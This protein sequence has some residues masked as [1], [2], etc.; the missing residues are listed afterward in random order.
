MRKNRDL[1]QRR[2]A[3]ILAALPGLPV[4]TREGARKVYRLWQREAFHP[5]LHFKKVGGDRWSIRVSIHYRAIGQFEG[6]RFVWS[7]IGTHGE[8]DRLA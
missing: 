6:N 4:A 2:H 7:W 8:Y 5:P 3:G 1:S